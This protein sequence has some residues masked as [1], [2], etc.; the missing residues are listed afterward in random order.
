MNDYLIA[1]TSTKNSARLLACA[2]ATT[3]CCGRCHT[4]TS[5]QQLAFS[6]RLTPL[7]VAKDY[8]FKTAHR[9]LSPFFGGWE[10][11]NTIAYWLCSWF[12]MARVSHSSAQSPLWKL[13]LNKYHYTL[14]TPPPLVSLVPFGWQHLLDTNTRQTKVKMAQ[15]A[16][17]SPDP[18]VLTLFISPGEAKHRPIMP[19]KSQSPN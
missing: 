8:C 14:A 1:A 12:T 2:E 5:A 3:A 16:H 17:T 13:A 18:G 7:T 9:R 15:R 6:L 19:D 10:V 11:F 4:G